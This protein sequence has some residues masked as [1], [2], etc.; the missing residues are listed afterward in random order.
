MMSQAFLHSSPPLSPSP[1]RG[2]FRTALTRCGY[3]SED[4]ARRYEDWLATGMNAGMAYIANHMPLRRDPALVLEGARSVVAMAFPYPEGVDYAPGEA[5]VAAYAQGDDYHDVLREALAPDISAL[6]GLLGGAWRLCIDSAPVRERYWA[7]RSGL[8]RRTRSGNVAVKGMGTRCFL[9]ILLTDVPP[10][11]LRP[12][13]ET[14]WGD[15]LLPDTPPADMAEA[16]HP[17]CHDCHRCERACP[18]KALHAGTVDARRCVSYLTIEHRGEWTSDE[19]CG[20]MSAPGAR[21]CL[22][23]CDICVRVCPLNMAATAERGPLSATAVPLDRFQPRE[24]IARLTRGKAASMTQEE[25]SSTFKGSPVKRAKLAGLRRNAL[26][27]RGGRSFGD[28][29]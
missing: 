24:E 10:E 9:A 25:F 14:L 22:F 1:T 20:V 13:L 27:L 3:V 4:E 6:T 21:N 23:G 18:G 11:V 29:G 26:G 7:V 28:G 15:S 8:G 5:R 19:A 17:A 12:A 16:L 2:H